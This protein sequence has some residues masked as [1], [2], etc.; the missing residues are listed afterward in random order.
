VTNGHFLS[1]PHQK[2]RIVSNEAIRPGLAFSP[3]R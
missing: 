1:S 3:A 2:T